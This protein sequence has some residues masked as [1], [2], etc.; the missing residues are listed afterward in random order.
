M[1]TRWGTRFK[2][3]RI[4]GNLFRGNDGKFT[5]GGGG[6]TASAPAAS[7]PAAGRGQAAAAR[8]ERAAAEQELRDQ[9]TAAEEA[10]R[11]DEDAALAQAATPKE[12]NALRQQI[13]RD[14]RQRASAL[15]QARRGRAAAERQAR[16]GEGAGTTAPTAAA[17]GKKP[18]GGKGGG[19]GGGGKQDRPEQAA[20]AD[21]AKREAATRRAEADARRAASEQ[22][23]AAGE[24]QRAER[25]QRALTDLTQRVESANTLSDSEWQRLIV[26]GLAERRG[27]ELRLTPAGRAQATRRPQQTKAARAG[28]GAFQVFKAAG[29]AYRWIAVSSSAFED[30]DGEIVSTKALAADCDRADGDGDYGPLRWWHIPGLDI[31]DCDFNAMSGRTLIEMGTFRSPALAEAAK[32]ASDDLDLSLGFRH[33]PAEPRAGVFTFI[34]RFER[35]LVPRGRASNLLTAFAVATKES[36]MDPAKVKAA[37]EMLGTSPEARAAMEQ[38]IT[39]AAEREKAA[40][41]AGIAYKDAPPWAQALIA[42]IDALEVA[43]KAPM[44]ADL[45]AAEALPADA[46]EAEAEASMASD[47]ADAAYAIGDMTRDEFKALMT[48]V[49]SDMAAGLTNLDGQLKAMGY[50]RKMKAY[51]DG[52]TTIGVKLD[53]MAATLKELNGD[54][55]AP[56]GGH[57]P[58]ADNDDLPEELAALFKASEAAGDGSP[59]G[60]V[61]AWLAQTPATR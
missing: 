18:K 49:L 53:A 44:P 6:D 55:P 57:R 17:L 8:R 20:S 14:R 21:A 27:R 16:A 41:E 22:R 29:G 39:G 40:E 38:I 60:Q 34:R 30:R 7:S 9:E 15:R 31:G 61:A 13:A 23:R 12:R 26:G 33:L 19:G 58:S 47:D 54:A 35:S 46:A 4:V 43:F 50:E 11:A 10:Q 1:R 3:K 45:A 36:R 25:T 51:E 42:R 48:E 5:A 52:L 24:A 56:R 32:A 28:A 2:A 59:L 37:L